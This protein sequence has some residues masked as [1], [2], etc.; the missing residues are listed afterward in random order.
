MVHR[1]LVLWFG[2][3]FC[4]TSYFTREKESAKRTI[5]STHEW[6]NGKVC[7]GAWN[8]IAYKSRHLPLS[9]SLFRS[10][11]LYLSA[12]VCVMFDSWIE[13]NEKHHLK[14][15]HTSNI[16]TA[17]TLFKLNDSISR[18]MAFDYFS[19]VWPVTAFDVEILCK[20]W[21]VLFF[22]VFCFSFC[23]FF[24][25]EFYR[26]GLKRWSFSTKWAFPYANQNGAYNF[27]FLR[28]LPRHN[29]IQKKN[30]RIHILY[31]NGH[32]LK[33]AHLFHRNHHFKW[34]PSKMFCQNIFIIFFTYFSFFHIFYSKASLQFQIIKMTLD[35]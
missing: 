5:C 18:S 33:V 2:H 17:G 13:F 12:C 27:F 16:Q 7:R 19:F 34:F 10:L 6:R 4:T 29:E 3:K 21:S 23:F 11:W 24:G 28:S 15:M 26:N 14:F 25:V 1:L 8:V 9:L 32:R 35:R 22:L 31:P 20:K 30:G